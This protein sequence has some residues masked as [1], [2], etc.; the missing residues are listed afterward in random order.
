MKDFKSIITSKRGVAIELAIGIILVTVAFSILLLSNGL[1][2]AD[3]AN[4]AKDQLEEKIAVMQI[5][6]NLNTAELENATY[7]AQDNGITIE[8]TVKGG[9]IISWQVTTE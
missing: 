1:L 9:K 3:K 4:A 8:Y 2:Q 7:T 6:E 5:L